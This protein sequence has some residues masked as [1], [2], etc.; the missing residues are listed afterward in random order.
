MQKSNVFLSI[1]AIII[2]ITLIIFT[3][4]GYADVSLNDSSNNSYQ[5]YLVTFKQNAESMNNIT[6]INPQKV[7]LNNLTFTELGEI[8][9]FI[10]PV[11]NTNLD[12]TT[13]LQTSIY[14]SNSEF[15][16]VNCQLSKSILTPNSSE[17][18][19]E[20]K[21]QLIKSPINYEEMAEISIDIISEPIY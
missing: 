2:L 9:T 18:I 1:T 4:I 5:E 19:I 11:T 21:V 15:F 13:K 8:Q 10:I 7:I 14:N 16:N 3:N 20:V 12:I 6:I 17:A